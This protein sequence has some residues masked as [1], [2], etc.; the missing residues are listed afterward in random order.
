MCVQYTH[1]TRRKIILF[2]K[3]V[4]YSEILKT[5]YR[6]G[7]FGTPVRIGKLLRIYDF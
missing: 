6:V 2:Y 3:Y 1:A 4:Y 7:N 5:V